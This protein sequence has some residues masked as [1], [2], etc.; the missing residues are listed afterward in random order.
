MSRPISLRNV[1]TILQH[2]RMYR[3]DLEMLFIYFS[4]LSRT[5]AYFVLI[6]NLF[7]FYNIMF[8]NISVSLVKMHFYAVRH[9][10]VL[11]HGNLGEPFQHESAFAY[12][13][14][15]WTLII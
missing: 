8:Y 13:F 7:L 11:L 12:F 6:S 4:V 3:K 2:Y 10:L 5:V 15:L 9:P 14:L 1:R